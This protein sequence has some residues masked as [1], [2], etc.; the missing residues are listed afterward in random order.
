GRM[1]AGPSTLELFHCTP[2]GDELVTC[3]TKHSQFRHVLS[4]RDTPPPSPTQWVISSGRPDGGIEGLWFRRMDDWPSGIYAG[5]PLLWTRLVVVSELP[6]TRGTLLLRLLGAG[7][8]LKQAIAE[9][10]ALPEEEPE[11][12]LALPVL[13]RLRLEVPTDP[14]KL[15]SDDQEF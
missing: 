15:T 2:N 13:V 12:R 11:R 14:L 3:L 8:V 9:L 6:V 1:T 5:P 10:K 4:L 7:Q